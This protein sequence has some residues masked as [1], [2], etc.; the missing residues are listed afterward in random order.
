[1]VFERG[2]IEVEI[3]NYGCK[4]K[5]NHYNIFKTIFHDSD[6]FQSSISNSK[7]FEAFPRS[8]PLSG[9]LKLSI[10]VTIPLWG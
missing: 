2:F 5:E 7:P 1:M 10:L 6:S 3:N 9:D 8:N 4:S